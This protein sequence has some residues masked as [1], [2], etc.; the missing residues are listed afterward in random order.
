MG[1][2]IQ[3]GAKNFGA[4]GAFKVVGLFVNSDSVGTGANKARVGR[5]AKVAS[6]T[7]AFQFV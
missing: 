4:Q 5:V 1:S 2:E 6:D 7:A 3:L